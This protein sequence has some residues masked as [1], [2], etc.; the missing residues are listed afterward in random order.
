[1]FDHDLFDVLSKEGKAM[2]GYCTSLPLYHV[3]FIF[4]NWNG[5]AGD[6][7]VLTHEAG[8]AFADFMADNMHP[9]PRPARTDNGG[10]R[11]PF[12]VDGIFDCAVAPPVLPGGHRQIR[13]VPRRKRDDLHP[14]RLPGRPLPGERLPASGVDPCRAQRR[15][16]PAGKAL[17]PASGQPRG[18]LLQP[19]TPAGSGSCTSSSA[20]STTS[21]TAWRR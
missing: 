11:E 6:V 1:M 17:P 14:L 2:G 7:D 16:E 12:D 10:L 5:T 3:P 9:A 8:H 21:I 4:A 13:A 20:R 15:V 19:R 18:Q